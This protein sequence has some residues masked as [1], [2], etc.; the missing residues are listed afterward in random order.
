M[1][2]G[3]WIVKNGRVIDTQEKEIMSQGRTERAPANLHLLAIE[4]SKNNEVIA[5]CLLK[6]GFQVT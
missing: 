5:R 4:S 6:I 3:Y 1:W 2:S